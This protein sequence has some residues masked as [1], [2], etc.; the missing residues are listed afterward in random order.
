MCAYENHIIGWRF[1]I[2][3]PD[4][5]FRCGMRWSV[6]SVLN[7]NFHVAYMEARSFIHSASNIA[8]W[9]KI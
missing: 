2:C 7:T 4:K 1:H 3:A 6:I 9:E 5:R 8:S